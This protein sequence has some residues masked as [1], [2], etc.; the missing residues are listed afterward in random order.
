M[1]AKHDQGQSISIL[2]I[3]VGL[4]AVRRRYGLALAHCVPLRLD[5]NLF[6]VLGVLLEFGFGSVVERA[7]DRMR[8]LL[9]TC[10]AWRL[11]L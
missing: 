8:P 5:Y 11:G 7:A 6:V 9:W 10:L 2:F 1:R 4:F 3:V